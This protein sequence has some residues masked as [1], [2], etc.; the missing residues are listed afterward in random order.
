[1][2]TLTSPVPTSNGQAAAPQPAPEPPPRRLLREGVKA[3]L[4]AVALVLVT[5]LLVSFW[6]KAAFIGRDRAVVGSSQLL[7]LIPGLLGQYLRRAFFGRVLAYFHYT[8]TVEFGVLF[9]KAG[10]RIGENV[11]IGPRCFIGLVDIEREALLSPGVHV[12]SG[13]RTHGFTD[14]ATPLREQPGAL[15]RVHI[16]AGAWI[17]S[18]AIVMADVG[19]DT[20][21]G[22]G[23]VVPKPLPERVIAAGVPARVLHPRLMGNGGEGPG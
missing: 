10:A 23:A 4:R 15:A 6:V 21:V 3:L 8:A 22:A 11:Y 16:R 18:G 17:G 20:V 13:P 1:M 7:S 9:S 2:T 19:R 5:P 14:L 12:T